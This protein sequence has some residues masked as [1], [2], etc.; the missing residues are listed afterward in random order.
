M[1]SFD[2]VE[3]S[4]EDLQLALSTS[5]VTSVDLVAA[6]LRRIARYDCRG[7]CLNSIPILNSHVFDEAAESDDRRASGQTFGRLEGIPYTVKDSYKVKGMTVASGSPAFKNLVANEDAFTAAAIRAQGGIVLGRTNMPPMAYGGMQRGVYGRAESPYNPEY[8]AAAWASGSSNGSAVST[9]ASFAAFGMGEETVSSGR[10][11]ASNNAVVAYTPSRGWISIRGNWPLYLTCDVIVPHTRSMSDLLALLEVIT[12]RDPSSQGDFWRDQPFVKLAEPWGGAPSPTPFQ[13]ISES[14]CLAGLRFAVPE[15]YIGGP[16]PW[17]AREVFVSEDV[18]QLWSQARKRLEALGAE[19][20][21]VS[22]FPAVTAY[23][24]P[25]LSPQGTA[26]LPED[27]NWYERGPLVAH[28]WDQFLRANGDAHIPGLSA[29]NELEIWPDMMRTEAELDHFPASN[30][31]HWGRL[32]Q[33]TERTSIYEV[34]NLGRALHTLEDMRRQLFDDYLAENDC[35][36]FVFPAQGDVA[37]ADSDVAPSSAEH[38]WRNGV[39][40]SNGNRAL[41]HLGIPSVTVSMGEM[42]TVCR[43]A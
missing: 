27:W 18:R 32:A 6:Y 3:A 41:R 14:K 43:L 40:Y 42:A 13:D 17:G 9:A 15:M 22:D 36:G 4:I 38:A 2:V 19:I 21:V 1:A 5:S 31:I 16:V 8:L 12:A 39:W 37:A 30:S 33:Y 24:T 28:G 26:K 25:G 7:P 29:V 10:S 23:E 35:D 20:V 11:P 34:K